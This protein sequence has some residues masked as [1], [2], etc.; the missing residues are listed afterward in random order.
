MICKH[1]FAPKEEVR[2]A[3]L[4]QLNGFVANEVSIM[5]FIRLFKDLGFFHPSKLDPTAALALSRFERAF[6]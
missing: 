4:T 3:R 5:S 6:A 2:K 1:F